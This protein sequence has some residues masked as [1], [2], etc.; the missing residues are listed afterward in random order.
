MYV[1]VF[2]LYLLTFA[3]KYAKISFLF[4][5]YFRTASES[6]GV[7]PD[8]YHAGGGPRK[9]DGAT[10]APQTVSAHPAPAPVSHADP[11]QLPVPHLRRDQV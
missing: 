3:C 5:F 11:V 7:Y 8:I 4:T 6:G 1:G 2:F 9:Q 10:P